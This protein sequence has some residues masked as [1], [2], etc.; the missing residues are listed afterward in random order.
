MVKMDDWKKTLDEGL[1]IARDSVAYAAGRAEDV[2]RVAAL[3]LRIF[4]LRRRIEHF[5]GVLGEAVYGLAAKKGDVWA[6]AA[7][8]KTVK[9]IATLEAKVNELFAQLEKKAHEAGR[10]ATAAEGGPKAAGRKRTRRRKTT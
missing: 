6:N 7:V 4:T 3:R 5:Y 1:A 9:E 10:R 2:S 8:R